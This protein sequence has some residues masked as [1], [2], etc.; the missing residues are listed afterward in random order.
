[1]RVVRI[2]PLVDSHSTVLQQS[3][4]TSAQNGQVAR[5]ICVVRFL[6]TLV[7]HGAG[8]AGVLADEFE[9]A[10]N[11]FPEGIRDGLGLWDKPLI[12]L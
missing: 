8:G 3:D 6:E 4:P 12:V 1:M 9:G 2:V 11:R 5:S 10:A 7:M